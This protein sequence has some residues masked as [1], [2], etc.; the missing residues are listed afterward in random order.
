MG[1]AWKAQ[2]NVWKLEQSERGSAGFP[3]LRYCLVPPSASLAALQD[4]VAMVVTI[5][6]LKQFGLVSLASQRHKILRRRMICPFAS[7]RASSLSHSCIIAYNQHP[8]HLR[9]ILSF[10]ISVQSFLGQDQEEQTACLMASRWWRRS[11][12][13]YL[14][15]SHILALWE[16]P[17]PDVGSWRWDG[18]T[19]HCFWHSETLSV[20]LGE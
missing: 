19:G 1:R 17:T 18:K 13:P 2:H 11:R 9:S 14:S 7:C 6:A 4:P 5:E 10:C 15:L 16:P 8:S 3:K 20:A 12:D